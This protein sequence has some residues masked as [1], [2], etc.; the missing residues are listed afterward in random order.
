MVLIQCS[1]YFVSLLL[2]EAPKVSL[3]FLFFLFF[4]RLLIPDNVFS[5][6]MAIQ[7]V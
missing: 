6:L 2:F 1:K 4:Q 7:N 5:L 3:T